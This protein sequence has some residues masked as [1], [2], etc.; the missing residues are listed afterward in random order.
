MSESLILDVLCL[1]GCDYLSFLTC[2]VRSD[3]ELFKEEH[4]CVK[5][6]KVLSVGGRIAVSEEF[7]EFVFNNTLEDLAP[8][9]RGL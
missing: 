6:L 2:R 3:V 8:L 9:C 7:D 4:L 5:V 1:C